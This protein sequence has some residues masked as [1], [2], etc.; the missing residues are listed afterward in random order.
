M[1]EEQKALLQMYKDVAKIFDKHGIRYFGMYGTELGAIRHE[2]FIPWDNDIDLIVFSDDMPYII[3]LMNTELDQS[4]YYFHQS[5]ADCHPHIIL[6][7][8]DFEDDLRNR[9]VIFM[10]LFLFHPYPDDWIRQKFFNLMATISYITTYMLEHTTSMSLYKAFNRI[11]RIFEK[12]ALMVIKTD[13]KKVAHFV[14]GFRKDIFEIDDFKEPLLHKFED[15]VIPIPMNWEK[16]LLMYFGDDYM[17]PPP[18]EERSG[19]M[20]YPVD[21]DF[22][23]ELDCKLEMKW[24]ERSRD[25]G[26]TVSIVVPFYNSSDHVYEC[27]RH[28]RQ[29]SYSNTEIIVVL[30]AE[31]DDEA[32]ERVRKYTGTMDNVKIIEQDDDQVD[33]KDIGLDSSTGDYVWFMDPDDCPSPFFVSEMLETA[34]EYDSDIVVC[35]HYCSYRNMVITPP[36]NDYRKIEMGG[37]EA[38]ARLCSGK[39]SFSWWNKLFK[40]SFLGKSGIRFDIDSSKG[41]G[42]TLRSFLAAGKV[43]YYNKPLYTH[44]VSDAKESTDAMN[45]RASARISEAMR[46]VKDHGSDGIEHDRFCAQIFR[47]I[48]HEMMNTTSDVFA[49][50]SKSDD[51][52]RLSRIKQEKSDRGVMMYRISPLIFYKCGRTSRRLRT[53]KNDRLFDNKI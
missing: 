37:N 16:F 32:L 28:I 47:L 23:Y 2:G 22:D 25:R 17:T 46:L 18:Q 8:D 30:S 5:R 1:N 53:I 14:P 12:L 36:N 4:R 19:A 52:Q 13:H 24:P 42:H 26:V 27:L 38:I 41:F 43:T 50:L 35:N 7:T 21:A 49:A 3:E 31:C 6:K 39:L 33:I 20:G 9:K 29:Q 10:D 40:R 15:T 11:P 48:L 51:V 44:V 34:L 45:E